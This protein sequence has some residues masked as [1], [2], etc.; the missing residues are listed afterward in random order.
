MLSGGWIE[1]LDRRNVEWFEVIST[2]GHIADDVTYFQVT[3]KI[4]FR[5]E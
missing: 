4:G 5:L 3:V 1:R 2:R